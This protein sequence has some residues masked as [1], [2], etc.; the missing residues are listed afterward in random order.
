MDRIKKIMELIDDI[1]GDPW[2]I[3]TPRDVIKPLKLIVDILV[4][5]QASEE[6]VIK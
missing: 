3:V 6:K 5:V 1:G 4:E 2:G